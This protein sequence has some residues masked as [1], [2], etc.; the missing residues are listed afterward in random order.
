MKAKPITPYQRLMDDF[1]EYARKVNYPKRV[2]MFLLP[3]DKLS[4]AWKLEDVWE[5]TKAAEQLG[6]DVTVRADDDGLHFGY[7]CKRPDTPWN[8]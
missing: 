3:K 8:V 7:V 4:Q 1:R 6:Y 5:R 2:A